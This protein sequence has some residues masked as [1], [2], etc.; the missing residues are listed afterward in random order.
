MSPIS[1][2]SLVRSRK[3]IEADHIGLMLLAAAGFDPCVALGV[4]KKLGEIV[5]DS[6]WDDY[7]GSHPSWKTRSRLLSQGKVI[8][9]ALELYHKHACMRECAE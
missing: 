9:E 5:G 1:C 7:I 4:H 3:E 8:E 6:P 2:V